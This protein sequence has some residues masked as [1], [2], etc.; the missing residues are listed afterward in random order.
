[1]RNT[2][3][4]LRGDPKVWLLD[5]LQML[6]LALPQ[7]YRH[8]FQSGSLANEKVRR[9]EILPDIIFFSSRVF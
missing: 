8:V 3:V 1:M 5:F 4:F 9:L 2:R 7:I 6:V